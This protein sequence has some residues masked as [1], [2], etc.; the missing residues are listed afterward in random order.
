VFELPEGIST[1]DTVLKNTI[2]ADL[3]NVLIQRVTKK[4]SGTLPSPITLISKA[5]GKPSKGD[6]PDGY[7]LDTSSGALLL[8]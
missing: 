2:A 6:L 3:S 1:S 5:S 7:G 8:R 4:G